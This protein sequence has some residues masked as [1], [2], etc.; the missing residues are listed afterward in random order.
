LNPFLDQ[1]EII[2]VGG[3]LN[4]AENMHRDKKNPIVLPANAHFT[5]LVFNHE[6][7]K[8]LHA[9][10]QALLASVREK[11]WPLGGRNIAKK[12]CINA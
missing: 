1:E 3:R 2:R 6:H 10:P 11:Y 8:L 9:G 7:V 12:Q 5:K 4:N